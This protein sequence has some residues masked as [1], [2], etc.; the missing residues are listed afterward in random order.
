M[1]DRPTPSVSVY[2][3]FRSV[4][5]STFIGFYAALSSRYAV[6]YLWR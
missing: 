4:T 2:G 5:A 6:F 3:M 1:P